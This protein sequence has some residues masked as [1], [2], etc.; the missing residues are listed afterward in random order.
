M[1]RM[2]PDW[3]VVAP[4]SRQKAFHGL[5]FLFWNSIKSLEILVLVAS[6]VIG[7][8]VTNW[9]QIKQ[10]G[11]RFGST[12]L[13]FFLA[14]FCRPLHQ[15][16]NCWSSSFWRKRFTWD[17]VGTCALDKASHEICW[18]GMLNGIHSDVLPWFHRAGRSSLLLHGCKIH[19][20][21]S[22]FWM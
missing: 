12:G 21:V 4:Y 3:A 13:Y 8:T 19:A 20:Q 14:F 18:G 7:C 15:L 11:D 16:L 9:R 5:G 10:P 2:V 22:S 6:N 1:S 17:L